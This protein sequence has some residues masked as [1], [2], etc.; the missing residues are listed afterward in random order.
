MNPTQ[1]WVLIAGASILFNV[2][3]AIG[4]Y[5]KSDL[6]RAMEVDLS[7]T[8]KALDS[9]VDDC[10]RNYEE[11]LQ[12]A[13]AAYETLHKA[14]QEKEADLIEAEASAASWESHCH[15]AEARAVQLS[16]S[17]CCRNEAKP[18]ITLG[19]ECTAT[20]QRLEHG[21]IP[22]PGHSHNFHA[23]GYNQQSKVV[24]NCSCGEQRLVPKSTYFANP[25]EVLDSLNASISP[26]TDGQNGFTGQDAQTIGG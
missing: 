10:D 2:I 20:I 16:K 21:N 4:Y 9:A 15:A 23:D 7:E 19:N 5:I 17:L 18:E 24:F 3:L 11:R 26:L 25:I 14:M 22:M 12:S 1:Q 8:R 6:L 13:A